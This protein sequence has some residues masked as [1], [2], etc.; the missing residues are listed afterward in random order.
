[1]RGPELALEIEFDQLWEA[2]QEEKRLVHGEDEK[3]VEQAGTRKK[4]KVWDLD[5][6]ER[7]EMRNERER[8]FHG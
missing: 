8:C 3:G 4:R 6:G 5:P 1:V 2:S 7:Q